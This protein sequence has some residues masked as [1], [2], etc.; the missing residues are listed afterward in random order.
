MLAMSRI[1]QAHEREQLFTP[2]FL[3]SG[4]EREIAWAVTRRLPSKPLSVLGETLHLDSQL[5]LVD[6]M[7]LYFDKMSMAASLEVRV[8]FMDHDVVSFCAALPDSRKVWRTRRKE[9][10]RRVS[11]GLV[12]DRIINKKKRGFFHSALDTWLRTHRE[13]LFEPLLLDERARGRGLYREDAVRELI[14]SAGERGKKPSQRLFA[15][16]ML[17]K[18]MRFYVDSDGGGRRLARGEQLGLPERGPVGVA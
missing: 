17:E 5:A 12:D 10:L 18:W 7:F 13:T 14:D 6:N 1:V 2:A 16:L 11:D 8:P 4:A 15:L 3:V 9:L